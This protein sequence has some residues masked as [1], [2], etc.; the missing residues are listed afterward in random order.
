MSAAR[1]KKPAPVVSQWIVRAARGH[2]KSDGMVA[3]SGVL[4]H[5]DIPV[6]DFDNDGRGGC[7]TWNVR[8][9]ALFADFKALADKEHPEIR[10][11]R[12]DWLAGK[13]W[14]AAVMRTGAV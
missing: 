10:Y 8:D 4:W 6:A 14:D 7:C 2:E 11:E 1:K 3:W 9:A 5:G 12:E 13:L